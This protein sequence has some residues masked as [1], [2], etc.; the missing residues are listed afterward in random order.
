MT[1]TRHCV[2]NT[3]FT[4]LAW[5]Q[6]SVIKRHRKSGPEGQSPGAAVNATPPSKTEE[7]TANGPAGASKY[8]IPALIFTMFCWATTTIVVRYTAGD[9][10]PFGLA[11]WRNFVAMVLILPFAL[12]ALRRQWPLIRAHLGLLAL[13]SALLWVGGNALLFLSL[14]YTI[15]INA[16]VINS[17]EPVFIIIAAAVL[18]QDRITLLQ[19]AGVV[20][21]LLGVL[22]L[23]SKGSVGTLLDL[24]FN[25]GD[26][27]VTCAY[28]FW[29]LYAV[30]LRKLPRGL[31]SRAMLFVIVAFGVVFLAPIYLLETLFKAPVPF[32]ATSVSAILGLGIFSCA[33]AMFLWNYA[34]ASMGAIRAGQYLHLIP[35]FT[36]ILAISLL[37]EAMGPHH[38]AGIAL[39]AAGIALTTRHPPLP[40]KAQA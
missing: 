2:G 24:D 16:A 36:V 12:V 4:A 32:N 17:V 40:G 31:D 14:Q 15:A 21:S 38:F 35:A 5:G 7:I 20:L 11:F 39:I 28:I 30:L 10:P 29:S 22:V 26:L 25:L 34:I 18:F 19:G 23:L 3:A 6:G 33:I 37:G 9:V 13:L 27:I 1:A 8:A